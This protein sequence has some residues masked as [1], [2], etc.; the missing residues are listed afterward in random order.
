MRK[1]EGRKLL[2]AAI[3]ATT[4]SIAGCGRTISNPKGPP[5][6][7]KLDAATHDGR[8]AVAPERAPEGALQDAPETEPKR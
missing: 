3:G 7:A 8:T 2:V 5:P 4:L 6:D 1:L